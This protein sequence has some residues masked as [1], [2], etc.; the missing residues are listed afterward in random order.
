[1]PPPMPSPCPPKTPGGVLLRK[2]AAERGKN[3]GFW[4]RA[5]NLTSNPVNLTSNPDKN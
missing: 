5:V 4:V 2:T 3:G 1:M